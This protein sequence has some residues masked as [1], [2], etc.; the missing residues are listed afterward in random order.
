MAQEQRVGNTL[1]AKPAVQKVGFIQRYVK[2]I[3]LIT[4]TNKE[5]YN[6]NMGHILYVLVTTTKN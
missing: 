4:G 2:F 6:V 5:T 3:N 1:E